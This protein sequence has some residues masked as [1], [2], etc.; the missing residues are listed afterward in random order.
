[1]RSGTT[2]KKRP[3]ELYFAKFTTAKIMKIMEKWMFTNFFMFIA[4]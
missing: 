4:V 3:P 1:M 2:G